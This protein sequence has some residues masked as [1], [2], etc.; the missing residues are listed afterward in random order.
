MI[1]YN[2]DLASALL[3]VFWLFFAGLIWYLHRENKREGYPLVGDNPNSRV[4]I[5][6]YPAPPPSKTYLMASGE[7]V[8]VAGG[9]PD[10]REIKAAPVSPYP[11]SPLEPT[12]NPML[13]GVGPASWAERADHPDHTHE[14]INKIVP[15]RVASDFFIEGRDPQPVG[16]AVRGADGV[17]A[18]TVRDVWVDRSEYIARYYE[19]ALS[20]REDTVLVPNNFCRVDGRKREIRVAAVN[21]E[22][23]AMAP[24]LRN[25]DSVTLLEEDKIMGFY[26]G[27]TL[28]ATA[29]RKE[30]FL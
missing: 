29:E 19:I 22:H 5:V 7:K 1:G 21:A 6:G 14:G 15:L 12:G 4:S 2:I 23:F 24:R 30:P 26:G 9:R 16:M 18:G 17:V 8:V 28:Y 11:G 13:D 3:Y 20:G 10:R 27:G 25:P